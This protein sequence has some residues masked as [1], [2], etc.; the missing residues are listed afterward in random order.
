M[1]K[2]FFLLGAAGFAVLSSCS[3]DPVD[4]L[5]PVIPEK[6]GTHT[7]T[8]FTPQTET[9]R[10]HLGQQ[11]GNFSPVYW[12]KNDD[13]AVFTNT[14][15][16]CKYVLTNGE[17]SIDGTFTVSDAPTAEGA[18]SLTAYYPYSAYN[19][20]GTFAIPTTQTYTAGSFAPGAN[21]MYAEVESDNVDA[22]LFS[23][24]AGVI[25]IRLTDDGTGRNVKSIKLIS[26]D[27]PLAGAGILTQNSEGA[28][29]I[30]YNANH[31]G[32]KQITLSCESV[33]LNGSTPTDFL[34]VVA[35]QTYPA[36]T[37]SFEITDT[38]DK[39]V[40]K[41]LSKQL[42]VG[43]AKII[44][45]VAIAIPKVIVV[46]SP[47][48]VSDAI[49]SAVTENK[50]AAPEV[51]KVEGN[52][53][54]DATV[55]IPKVFQETASLTIEVPQVIEN[56]TLTFT[57]STDT[58]GGEE[59]NLPKSVNIVT[60]NDT[61]K[62]LVVDMP[63]TTVTVNGK[64]AE[65]TAKTAENTLN[66]D[67]N[68]VITKLIVKKG[69]VKVY[70]TVHEISKE[71][72]YTGT[73]IG[74]IGTQAGLERIIDKQDMFDRIVIEKAVTGLDGKAGTLTKPLEIAANAELANLT[75]RP[76]AITEA[77]HPILVSGNNAKVVLDGVLLVC[78]TNK[79][80]GISC[81]GQNPDV[82]IRN[83]EIKALGADCRGISIINSERNSTNSQITVDNT[84]IHSNETVIGNVTYSEDQINFF[85]SRV[86]DS[87]YYPRGISVGS[88]G[89]TV[90]IDILNNSA[91]E[92]FF[93]AVNI[94]GITT[95]VI[96]NVENSRLDGRAALN[97]HGRECVFNIKGNSQLVGRNYF[98]G[99]TEEFATIV[100][101]SAVSTAGSNTVTVTDSEIYSYNSPQQATNHQYSA[102]L[103]SKNNKLSLLGATKLIEVNTP[104]SAR[105]NFLVMNGDNSNIIEVA[106]SVTVEGKPGAHVL[107][108][109]L[110]DGT[111][112]TE[113]M[114]GKVK[115]NKIE[116]FCY[117][118][119]E[120]SDLAWI[121]Q[122]ANAGKLREGASVL[123]YNDL[124]L[125]NHKWT[126]IGATG[127]INPNDAETNYTKKG[128]LFSG[129]I[130]GNGHTIRNV[131][132]EEQ[133][134]A[135]GIFGQVYG[136]DATPVV[137]DGLNAE[138]VAIDGEGKWTGGLVGYVRNVSKIT[139]CSIRNVTIATGDTFHTYGS[140]GLVGYISNNAAIEI[141]NCSS[142]NVEFKGKGGWNNGGL[143][144]KLYGNKTVT[145][146]DCTP[147]K[148]YFRTTLA[149]NESLNGLTTSGTETSITPS[150]GKDGYQNSWFIG[151]IT[152]QNG[153]DLTISNI[154][155]NSAN[156]QAV[157][158]NSN[159][160]T[161]ALQAGA[162]A[163]PYVGVYDGYDKT[164]TGT[165]TID[166]KQVYPAAE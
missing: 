11:E 31:T 69:N 67:E 6:L 135:R 101:D 49:K 83:S 152:A 148:G 164:L 90:N 160:I 60:D 161:N 85:K 36:G 106:S 26:T 129:C 56:A 108:I 145:V 52:V 123:F 103:R 43:R 165:L 162:Y 13:I 4:E 89:S 147:A 117:E 54:M 153:F 122:E 121:A 74:C 47:E 96:V 25:N 57:E 91:I 166:G 42:I 46:E 136:P 109:T 7:L 113:P 77:T 3:T 64:Y 34:F 18:S 63:N 84:S 140:G 33:V 146:A 107:P 27:K 44:D 86:Q 105:M 20:N 35:A 5:T 114:S 120:A 118:I 124:D 102:D 48:K 28:N 100:L 24:V 110:W 66:V 88:T 45:F 142:E 125:G 51:V 119:H 72:S 115:D 9:T 132:I 143:I 2:L 156:W 104:Q 141:K 111:T 93:Y 150:I 30:G 8:A 137:I 10:T 70:G 16:L 87:N 41:T 12:S 155:D 29:V 14:G 53:S 79:S 73:I 75:I 55:T 158:A 130:F 61:A 151:N 138:N 133:T 21:P 131:L 154:T 22:L 19:T 68:A 32:E 127:L 82:T 112:V 37:L 40:T 15:K 59:A 116:W 149:I 1:K 58:S 62:K 65:M 76:A 17:A 71:N 95:P 99:P 94:A 97:V 134:P 50:N 159:D 38:E 92:G 98:T 23:H 157:D 128:H 126:P 39:T 163:W 139:D 78:A 144:G 81:T 80:Y